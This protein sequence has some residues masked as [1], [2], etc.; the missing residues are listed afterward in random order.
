MLFA[1]VA[2]L[3]LGWLIYTV[4]EP[5]RELMT[6]YVEY[7]GDDCLMLSK[8]NETNITALKDQVKNLTDLK[9]QVA[10]LDAIAQSNKQQLSVMVDQMTKK[11]DVS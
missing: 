2:A 7:Q 3:L 4:L 5:R 1:F 11:M 6:N 8:Q 10:Q 9:D